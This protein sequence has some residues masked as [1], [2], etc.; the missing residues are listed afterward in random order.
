MEELPVGT[1]PL[2]GIK[3]ERFSA[4]MN[5]IFVGVG[6]IFLIWGATDIA[7]PITERMNVAVFGL[8]RILL[9]IVSLSVGIG[10]ESVQWAKIGKEIT[11]NNSSIQDRPAKAQPELQVE[12]VTQTAECAE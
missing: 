7:F 6:I 12:T 9:G 8:T 10:V 11:A 5:G 2:S 1:M 4:L 3:I